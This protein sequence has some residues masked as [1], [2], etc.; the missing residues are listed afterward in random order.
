MGGKERDGEKGDKERLQQRV[1][2]WEN[3]RE[4]EEGGEGGV[5]LKSGVPNCKERVCLSALEV[6]GGLK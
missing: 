6:C 3:E 1:R 2:R 5:C 4:R